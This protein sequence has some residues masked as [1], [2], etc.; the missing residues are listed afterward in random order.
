MTN[1]KKLKA[2]KIVVR[3]VEKIAPDVTAVELEVHG[4]PDPPVT[5][6][7]IDP[8]ELEFNDYSAGPG[9]SSAANES[10]S[11]A[12]V[13]AASASAVGVWAWLRSLW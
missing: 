4:A 12:A 1:K 8:L 13:N 6:P 7:I 2:K 11:D 5:L 10:A 3:K 9:P